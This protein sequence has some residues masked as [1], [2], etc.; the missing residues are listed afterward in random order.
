MPQFPERAWRKIFRG[1]VRISGWRLEGELP[2][3]PKA[4][5]IAAPHSSWWDGFHGLL[6]KIALGA[7]IHF[8]AKRELFRGPQGLLLQKLGGIPIERCVAH[9]V[10]AQMVARLRAREKLWLGIAP[11]GT[12]RRVAQWKAGFWYIARGAGVPIVPVYFDYLRRVI[13][14]GPLFTTSADRDADVAALRAFYAPYR[15]KHRGV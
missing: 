3:V 10:T 14:V 1:I 15:G 5:L 2:D 9:G 8:M 11:E 4:V 13:G 12:R 7:D 6:F